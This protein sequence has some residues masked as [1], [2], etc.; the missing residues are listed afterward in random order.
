[1]SQQDTSTIAFDGRPG[2]TSVGGERNSGVVGSGREVESPVRLVSILGR[3]STF[4]AVMMTLSARVL[5]AR[6]KVS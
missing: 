3:G 2:L 4:Y 5:A 6:P 1:M